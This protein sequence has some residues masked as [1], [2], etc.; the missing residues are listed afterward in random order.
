MTYFWNGCSIHQAIEAR[1]GNW[2]TPTWYPK[3][4]GFNR[5]HMVNHPIF[6]GVIGSEC[7]GL[8]GRNGVGFFVDVPFHRGLLK[9][10]TPKTLPETYFP[11]TD[12]APENRPFQKKS[13]LP[14]TIFLGAV[15]L[16]SNTSPDFCIT[17]GLYLAIR[18]FLEQNPP[19]AS[20]LEGMLQ[21]QPG[22]HQFRGRI[23]QP[24]KKKLARCLMVQQKG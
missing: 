4:P 21:N 18:N 1:F 6:H 10:T 2:E 11:K 22:F 3:R 12:I 8:P 5:W 24:D 20:K 15:F 17:P 14:T 7:F 23:F 13:A 16:F 9:D 19:E